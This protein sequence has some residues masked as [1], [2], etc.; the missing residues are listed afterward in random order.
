MPA[1][2]LPKGGGSGYA[3]QLC[4]KAVYVLFNIM[5]DSNKLSTLNHA[6]ALLYES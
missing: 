4:Q 1:L 5:L 2:L 3:R 6:H